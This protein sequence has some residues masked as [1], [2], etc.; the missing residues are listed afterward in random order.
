MTLDASASS[1]PDED[2][3]TFTWIEGD[4]VIA[5]PTADP[6]SVVTLAPGSHVITLLVEDPWGEM[7]ADDVAAVIQDT[8]PP[9]VEQAVNQLVSDVEA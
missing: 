2:A 9:I 8:P 7:D 1:D 4:V 5:G 6:Q 3:L